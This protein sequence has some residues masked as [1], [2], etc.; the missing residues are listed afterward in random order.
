MISENDGGDGV[1]L[2]APVAEQDPWNEADVY[3]I[4]NKVKT[5]MQN[6]HPLP[7]N[8]LIAAIEASKRVQREMGSN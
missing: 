6:N 2:N 8:V 5:G 4:G 1:Q 7:E 3:I